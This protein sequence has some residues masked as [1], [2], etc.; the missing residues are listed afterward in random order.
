MSRAHRCAWL[1][2][3]GVAVALSAAADEG[4]RGWRH[5]RR[6]RP[7]LERVLEQHADR[8]QLDEATRARIR[9]ISEESRAEREEHRERLHALH[10][11]MRDI[12]RQDA[13]DEEAVMRKADEIGAAE[14]AQQKHRLRTLL[15]IRALLTPTQR[16]ELVKILLEH[17]EFLSEPRKMT[18]TFFFSDVKSFTSI[19][20]KMDA[21]VLFPF[22]NRYLDRMTQSLK[23]H[24]AFVDKYIGDGIMA[25]FGIPVSTPD[26]AKLACQAA[27]DCQAGLK[28]LNAEF[29]LEGLPEVK[30]RIGIHSGD[31][32]RLSQAKDP[33]RGEPVFQLVDEPYRA[34]T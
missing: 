15:Q 26:H 34:W 9:R 29:R 21:D 20:E 23:A 19:S 17:P 7:S 25:L 5:H 22:I 4:E 1:A 16:A 10:D 8:L 18:G 28:P 27:L 30:V 32:V 11:Q 6:G 14:T 33:V 24:Q 3:A 31:R 13:P 12:L 2:V